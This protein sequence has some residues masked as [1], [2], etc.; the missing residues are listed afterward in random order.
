MKINKLARTMMLAAAGSLFAVATA[1]AQALPAAQPPVARIWI[2]HELNPNESMAQPYVRI[3]GG[4]IGASVP[5]TA[6]YRDLPA[7]RHQISV[8]SYVDDGNQIKIVDLVPGSQVYAKIVPFGD[9]VQGGG[10]FGG[11]YHRNTYYL[12]LYPPEQAQPVI[13]RGQIVAAVAPR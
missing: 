13:A 7:G 5:G 1:S 10:E 4:V 6:F 3:D 11:G 12:W 8:E 9:I 2:Y